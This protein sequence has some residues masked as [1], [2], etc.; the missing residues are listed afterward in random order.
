MNRVASVSTFEAAKNLKHTGDEL[1]EI[2]NRIR[3]LEEQDRRN[4]KKIEAN[5]KCLE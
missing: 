3:L 1:Q 4:L 2:H 5:H